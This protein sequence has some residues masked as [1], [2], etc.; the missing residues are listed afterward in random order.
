MT[1]TD[2]PERYDGFTLVIGP[3]ISQ[4]YNNTN[5]LSDQT[6]TI[7]DNT[8]NN[9]LSDYIPQ[10]SKFIHYKGSVCCTSGMVSNGEYSNL[11]DSPKSQMMMRWIHLHSGKVV[12]YCTLFVYS[13][14]SED[15]GKI[16]SHC[17]RSGHQQKTSAYNVIY[18][19][20]NSNKP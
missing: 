17:C 15:F 10:S 13:L 5:N 18:S 3:P 12:I 1:F 14:P 20:T 4:G 7:K 6:N 2:S 16:T 9:N 8:I 11:R 19:K